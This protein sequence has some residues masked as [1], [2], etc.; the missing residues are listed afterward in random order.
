MK[1]KSKEKAKKKK[2]PRVSAV[3]GLMGPSVSTQRF[4]L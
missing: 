4:L 3:L 1:L 2:N